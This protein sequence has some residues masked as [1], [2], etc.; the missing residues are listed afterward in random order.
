MATTK[1]TTTTATKK[2]AARK[3]AVKKS[4]TLDFSKTK[5]G[6]TKTEEVKN[7]V[8]TPEVT[9]NVQ[10][11]GSIEKIETLV[12]FNPEEETDVVNTHYNSNLTMEK[13][14]EA[15]QTVQEATAPQE[16]VEEEDTEKE[17]EEEEVKPETEPETEPESEPES[18]PETDSSETIVSDV[19]DIVNSI[20]LPDGSAPEAEVINHEVCDPEEKVEKVTDKRPRERNY[21]SDKF[22]NQW[23]GVIYDY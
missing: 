6:K 10:V 2:E 3:A 5:G 9:V 13:V 14:E 21:F 11:P 20:A 22:G 16:T 12:T 7:E 19:E 23:G 15:A 1:K 18:E 4:T 17:P 8:E